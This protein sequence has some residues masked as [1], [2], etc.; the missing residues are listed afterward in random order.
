MSA[1]TAQSIERARLDRVE[2]LKDYGPEMEDLLR[3]I[4]RALDYVPQSWRLRYGT[5]G[6]HAKTRAILARL[7]AAP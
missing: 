3:A 5:D 4:F 1:P 2:R 6:I 7:D